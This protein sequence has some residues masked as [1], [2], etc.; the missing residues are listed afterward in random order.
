V[1][2]YENTYIIIPPLWQKGGA[3]YYWV[4]IY[5]CKDI[6]KDV[7]LFSIGILDPEVVEK[8]RELS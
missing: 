4:Y 3:F 7:D 5:L 1:I 8:K 2:F 6:D